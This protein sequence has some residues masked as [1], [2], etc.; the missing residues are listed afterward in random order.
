VHGLRAAD[1]SH[2]SDAVTVAGE[3]IVRRG[4]HGGVIGQTEIVVGAEIDHLAAV[5]QTNHRPLS[6]ADE[7]LSLEQAGGVERQ[8]VAVQPLAEF[9]HCSHTVIIA[10]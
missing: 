10:V 3:R 7:S 5:V 6:R 1:E 8:G 4:D 2:R 9:F